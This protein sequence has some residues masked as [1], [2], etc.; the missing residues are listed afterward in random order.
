MVCFMK[1]N[2]GET[3]C[4]SFFIRA[5]SSF[6]NA[7]NYSKTRKT[8]HENNSARCS[9]FLLKCYVLYLL[10]DGVEKQ[11]RDTRLWYHPKK[12]RIKTKDVMKLIVHIHTEISYILHSLCMYEKKEDRNR[13]LATYLP[14]LCTVFTTELACCTHFVHDLLKGI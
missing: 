11:E 6:S 8:K 4:P 14:K 9:C 12:V 3:T 10:I 13:S 5:S 2:D 7:T 1:N